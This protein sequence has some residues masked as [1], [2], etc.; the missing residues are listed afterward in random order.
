M[1][2]TENYKKNPFTLI[3][4]GAITENLP[5]QV[6]IHPVSYMLHGL[7]IAANVYPPGY[8]TTLK[9]P[10]I[11]SKRRRKGTGGRSVCPTSG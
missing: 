8:T 1:A 11:V 10:A 3:Y 6:N 5:G 7:K 2:Q 4:K 9:Y